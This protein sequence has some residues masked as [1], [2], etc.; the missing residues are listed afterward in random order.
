MLVS[1]VGLKEAITGG[2]L[3]VRQ[4]RAV[5]YETYKRDGRGFIPDKVIGFFN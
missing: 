5:W 4:Q 3:S 1:V 2:K